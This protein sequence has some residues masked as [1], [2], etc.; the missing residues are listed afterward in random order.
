[1]HTCLAVAVVAVSRFV[2]RSSACGQ[3]PRVDFIGILHVIVQS[4][5][6]RVPSRAG[7]SELDDRVADPRLAML[8]VSCCIK[9]HEPLAGCKCV[10]DELK[11]VLC[12]VYDE[13][14]SQ[15]PKSFRNCSLCFGHLVLLTGA[16]VW[17]HFAVS[18]NATYCKKFTWTSGASRY[19]QV[20]VVAGKILVV[21]QI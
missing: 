10:L 2:Q 4:G 17:T 16:A 9:R 6:H 19:R 3:R 7:V 1:M 12:A 15:T 5:W 13:I 21:R 20:V 18:Y 14:G 8:D 11:E